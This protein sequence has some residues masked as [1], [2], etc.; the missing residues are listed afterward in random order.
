MV[1]FLRRILILLALTSVISAPAQVTSIALV[2]PNGG[3]FA[4]PEEAR[5]F[6]MQ[7]V[8]PSHSEILTV[9]YVLHSGTALAGSDFA[10]GAGKLIFQPNEQLKT[11]TVR[12]I[13]DPLLEGQEEF[14][15]ELTNAPPGYPI[16]RSVTKVTIFDDE[17]GYRVHDVAAREDVGLIQVPVERVGDFNF[18]SSVDVYLEPN[19]AAAGVDYVNEA[20]TVNFAPNQTRTNIQIRIIN[21]EVEDGARTFRVRLKNPTAGVP[22]DLAAA[23]IATI[24]DNEFGYAFRL[25]PR[26][27]DLYFYE[28]GPEKLILERRGD[29]ATRTVATVTAAPLSNVPNGWLF[30]PAQASVDFIG[31]EFQVEFAPGQ[32]AAEVPLDI[33]NDALPETQEWIQLQYTTNVATAGLGAIRLAI[34]DNEFNPLP[35]RA[36]CPEASQPV[37]TPVLPLRDG[38]FLAASSDSYSTYRIHRYTAAGE[39]DPSFTPIELNGAVGKMME[40]A[41]GKYTVWVYRWQI[42]EN[43]I[44]RYLPDGHRDE[45]FTPKVV[46]QLWDFTMTS[47]GKVYLQDPVQRLNNDGSVDSTFAPPLVSAEFILLDAAE[48]VYIRKYGTLSWIRLTPTG[49]VDPTF[50]REDHLLRSIHGAIFS[51]EGNNVHRLTSDGSEDPAF[52][53]IRD[54][55][56]EG[57]PG[58]TLYSF[59]AAGS[60][61]F[62]DRYKADGTRDTS[63]MRATLDVKWWEEL[64]GHYAMRPEGSGLVA[65]TVGLVNSINGTSLACANGPMAI[66]DIQLGVSAR[67]GAI[68][69]GG[70]IF[71]ERDGASTLAFIRTG[72]N[73]AAGKLRYE[74]LGRSALPGRHYI[75]AGQGELSFAAGASRAS[76]PITIIDNKVPEA[77][78]VLYVRI[79]ND[80]GTTQSTTPITIRNEDV[81]IQILSQQGNVMRIAGFGGEQPRFSLMRSADLITWSFQTVLTNGVPFDIR[82]T[83]GIGFFSGQSYS[84]Y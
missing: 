5:E 21:N 73:S 8:A 71:S 49:A 14:F 74:V 44:E 6:S 61:T 10:S 31:S 70:S 45:S 58:G 57:G 83:N 35:V 29:Y 15:I 50:A 22:A 41:D 67:R 18:A 27:A 25:P 79:L 78:R 4:L 80:D 34:R 42:Q 39:L 33:V 38:K 17:I 28:G 72:D 84:G 60:E 40:G 46:G 19:T 30:P 9:D 68:E 24:E 2:D 66:A 56:V 51:F 12:V 77:D 36:F 20:F 37:V 53:T 26:S 23:A 62:V 64:W 81:G 32:T 82:M 75:T 43:R 13:D 11:F 76:A 52:T 54:A 65:F 48:N 1:T 59:R 7:V 47:D 63:H 3:F 69:P 55:Y 16:F